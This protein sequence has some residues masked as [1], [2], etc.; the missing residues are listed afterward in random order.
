MTNGRFETAAFRLALAALLVLACGYFTTPVVDSDTWWHLATGRFIIESG[1]IPDSD[2]FGVYETTNYWGSTVLKGQWLGQLILFGAYRV[3]DSSA[4]VI[5]R[6]LLL[7]A[8]FLTLVYRCPT[9][10][11]RRLVTLLVLFIAAMA[12]RGYL[13]DRPQAF[14]FAYFALMVLLLEEFRFGGHRKALYALPLLF[15]A[16]ANTHPGVLLGAA[17]LGAFT[18]MYIAEQ[19][20]M[21][22]R[23][24]WSDPHVLLLT[25]FGLCLLAT[26]ATPNGVTTYEYLF[27]LQADP[28]QGRITEYLSPFQLLP[29]LRSAP[30]LPYYW[31]LCVAAVPTLVILIRKRLI[32]EG[33]LLALIIAI[34]FD[35]NRY[36]PF[37]VIFTAPLIARHAGGFLQRDPGRAR[38][39]LILSA[40][41][42]FAAFL[43][44]GTARGN[45]FRI[46]IMSQLYPV[47]LAETVARQGLQGRI[48]NTLSWGGYLTWKLWPANRVFID[49]RLMEPQRTVPYTHIL[50]MTED[51]REFFTQA[52]FSLV[53]VAYRNY[54]APDEEVYPLIEYL[55]RHPQWRL[56]QADETGV[57]FA[58]A[59]THRRARGSQ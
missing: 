55:H 5:L 40:A 31:V 30:F 29:N 21:H 54:F 18:V 10:P 3:G 51:G 22:R 57:L 4:V 36:V 27:K 12:L 53:M 9:D 8:V 43:I 52:D 46:G 45:A 58:S 20:F 33:G 39:G 11:T 49:G 13:S 32:V 15:V 23:G 48:F 6:V 1:T 44:V 34:S 42:F 56:V 16:W 37:M 26:V 28:L 14:S 38:T 2:P 19:R 50:W 41:L 24:A 7:T 35:A 25:V 47:R 59:E 17:F